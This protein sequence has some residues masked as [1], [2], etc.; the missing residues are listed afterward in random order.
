MRAVLVVL[1]AVLASVP[2]A[3]AQDATPASSDMHPFVGTWLLGTDAADPTNPPEVVIAT[4]EG[5]Y[6]SANADGTTSVGTWEATGAQTATLTLTVLVQGAD[7]RFAGRLVIRADV[8][9]DASGTA[10]TGPYTLA[11]V[12]PDGTSTP[13]FGPV[14]ATATRLTPEAMGTPAGP[15]SALFELLGGQGGTPAATPAP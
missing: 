13:E 8:E 3:T 11:F 4:A 1:V 9:V 10:F 6:V 15:A 12:A 5:D 14:T 7:G 2:S